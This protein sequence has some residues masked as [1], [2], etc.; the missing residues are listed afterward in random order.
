MGLRP[1][2]HESLPLEGTRQDWAVF[3]GYQK[4]SRKNSE[5]Y[6]DNVLTLNWVILQ[7]GHHAVHSSSERKLRL[8]LRTRDR[9]L[10]FQC[11]CIFF[12]SSSSLPFIAY[13]NA[14]L[15]LWSFLNCWILKSTHCGYVIKDFYVIFFWPDF[16]HR[17][18]GLARYRPILSE[19][20]LL[21]YHLEYG[22]TL[23]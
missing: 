6:S 7:E 8:F 2:K 11:C 17:L 18:R 12:F 3:L 14:S 22:I 20:G 23:E 19:Y 5:S 4:G 16:S 1:T 10:N 21:L 15:D 9:K 13:L